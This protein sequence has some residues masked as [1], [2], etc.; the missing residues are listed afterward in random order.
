MIVSVVADLKVFLKKLQ[1]NVWTYVIGIPCQMIWIPKN[2]KLN[3]I[4]YLII[5]Y[6][7]PYKFYKGSLM[8]NL[9]KELLL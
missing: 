7:V 5:R 6:G 1:K 8:T 9:S 4:Q 2:K 3:F